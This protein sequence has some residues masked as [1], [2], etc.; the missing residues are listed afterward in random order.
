VGDIG[1]TVMREREALAR[2]GFVMVHLDL[3]PKTG[4][5]RS[6][7]EIVSKG[8]VF[9]RDSDE[10]FDAARARIRTL[11]EGPNGVDLKTKVEKELG[12]FF[13]AETKRSP[14]IFVFSSD[15]V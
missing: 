2:D 11:A 7:P 4:K 3:S 1:P 15:G 9:V 5:L 14:M 10:L 8:F 13:Y 6:E 12:K